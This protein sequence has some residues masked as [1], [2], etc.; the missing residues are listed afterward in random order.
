MNMLANYLP[1][2]DVSYQSFP[3]LSQ[4][5][6]WRESDWKGL[7]WIVWE[8]IEVQAT[9]GRRTDVRTQL[10]HPSMQTFQHISKE[11]TPAIHQYVTHVSRQ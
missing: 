11:S 2:E 10:T 7:G 4:P 8:K 5:Q 1:D 3:G 9:E 6:E